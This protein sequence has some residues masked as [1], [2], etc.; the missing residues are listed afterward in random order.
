V[1]ERRIADNAITVRNLTKRFGG[2]VA[3]D[4]LSFEVPW[5][6][7]T[8]FLGPNGAGKSTTLRILLGLGAPSSGSALIEGL[9]YSE[10]ARPGSSVGALLETQQFHPQR[11]ARDHLRVYAA[12][13]SVPDAR[14]DEVLAEVGLMDAA[15]KKVGK[16]SLGMKQRL[17]LAGALLTDPRILILDEPANGL[18]PAG[19]KWL[20][21]FLKG[22]VSHGKAV[23]VSSHLLD[24]IAHMAEDVVVID[25]GRLV[26][27]ASVQELTEQARGG[28]TVRTDAPEKLRDL[29]THAGFDAELVSHESVYITKASEEEIGRTAATNGVALFGIKSEEVSLEDVFLEI[30]GSE[31]IR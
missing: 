15:K 3:V 9:P 29:M 24:E 21:S 14:V 18:D 23:F 13:S 25:H 31:E 11:R 28:I 17:G 16:F 20:R 4:D 7:I 2:Q 26:T 12:A 19:I 27:H 6:R 10:L 30:T 22:F 1:Q 8:G 5:G